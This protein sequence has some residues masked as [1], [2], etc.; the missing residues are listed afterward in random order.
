[1]T[2]LAAFFALRHQRHIPLF[3]IVAAPLLADGIQIVSRWIERGAR[4]WILTAAIL[5]V[6]IYQI[7]WVSRVH[8]QHRFQLVVSPQEYPL[9]AADFLRRNGIQGNLAV[10]FDWG[11]YLIWK[12]Y[13]GIRVSIDGRYTTAY[14]MEVIQDNWEWIG[15][16]RGWRRLL[17]GHP[18]EI[19]ITKRHHPVTA[20]LRKDPEWVYIY[21]D[22]IAFI[23][24]RKTPS[25]EH[26]LD[27]F[28]ARQL[29]HPQPPP[30]YFPG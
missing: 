10:P 29:L 18:T 9:Q 3:A 6:A 19:A 25:Q 14:P 5:V 27:K 23:F 30:V 11:E 17:E 12:L 1:L 13:P 24:V 22:P 20:L 21:S 28:R 8:L 15:G 2:V 16:G 4:E 7:F 26:L